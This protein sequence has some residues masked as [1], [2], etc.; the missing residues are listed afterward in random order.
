VINL[1]KHQEGVDFKVVSA[2]KEE[3]QAR[4]KKREKKK[5]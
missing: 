1:I 4:E 5:T 3:F 2:L